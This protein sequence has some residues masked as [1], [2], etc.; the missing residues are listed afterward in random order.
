MDTTFA[1]L[2]LTGHAYGLCAAIAAFVLLAAMG[3]LGYRR[4]LPPGTVRVFGLLGIVLGVVCAREVYCAG[5]VS[6]FV[7]MYEDPWLMLRFWDGGLSMPGMLAGLVLAALIAARV[8]NARFAALLDVMCAP[9]GLCI[10]ILRFGEQFT[11]LGVGKVVGEGFATRTMP[12]LFLQ[13]RMGVSV[14]YR[15]NV[16]AYE[17]AA[18]V[19]VFVA[20]LCL[21]RWLHRRKYARP[22][23]TALFF[24]MLY[25]AVQT[26]LESMRD[27]GHMLI[28]FLRVG[29]LAAAL[30][31][32]IACG[33]L[34]ARYTGLNGGAD[35]R[36]AALWCVQAVCVVGLILLEFSLDGRLSW[37]VPSMARDY[38]IMAA[39]C[40]L[41]FAMP[42][43][44]L[45]TL[46]R[47]LYA[48]RRIAVHVPA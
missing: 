28:I 42:F 40:A 11:D 34:T 17:A 7:E 27:D 14:E 43:S 16:W 6:T 3:L 20:V 23:D 47:R 18:G 21:Y 13:T 15:M 36:I 33:V 35:K 10:A 12:W 22:G 8:M 25:G 38:A 30:M 19:A 32:L 5:N 46:N 4:K 29:Q 44:L 1:F 37:G 9:L 31:P 48:Q 26:L 41:L 39:L 2:G 45:M 24:F